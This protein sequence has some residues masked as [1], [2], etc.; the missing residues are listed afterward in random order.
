MAVGRE[1][2]LFAG[3]WAIFGHGNVAGMGEA[4]CRPHPHRRRLIR[5]GG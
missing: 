4:L 3:C 5:D 2:P 1:E